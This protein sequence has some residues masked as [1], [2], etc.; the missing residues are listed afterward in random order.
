[1]ERDSLKR[2][3]VIIS[4]MNNMVRSSG[5]AL[6]SGDTTF[7]FYRFD[8]V[9][10]DT[11]YFEKYSATLSADDN[12][13]R[14][15]KVGAISL[16][17]LFVPYSTYPDH[18]GLLPKFT[19]P[20]DTGSVNVNSL[21]P[22]NPNKIFGSGTKNL[23]ATDSGTYNSNVWSS[24]GHGITAAMT[25]SPYRTESTMDNGVHSV[26][27]FFDAD[28]YTRK[29]TELLDVRGIAFRNPLIISGPGYDTS[30]EPVP[31]GVGG[32]M[33]PQAYSNPSLWKTGPLDVR[34][35]AERAV[36]ASP[37]G[38][39]QIIRFELIAPIQCSLCQASATVKSRPPGVSRVYGESSSGTVTVYDLMNGL[40]AEPQADLIGRRGYA[41]L[42][43][44][45]SEEC[46]IDPSLTKKWEIMSLMCAEEPCDD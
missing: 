26:T 40:L 21:N 13:F 46:A 30:G 25:L 18:T 14:L 3:Q 10:V 44:W 34:W 27:N 28:Y 29:K 20:T 9:I 4:T 36:W 37:P 39:V 2:T 1:M 23:G 16:D 41:V 33:H 12:K 19:T 6:S 11:D 42:L 15:D 24:G 31:T 17:G 35:D 32:I 38:G 8:T 43:D 7:P 45:D 5:D 22:F